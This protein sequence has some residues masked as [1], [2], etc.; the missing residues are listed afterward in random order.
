MLDSRSSSN[1]M[2]KKAMELLNLRISRPYHNICAMDSKTIEVHGLINGL[3]VHLV[4][5]PNIMIEMD[6]ILIDVLDAWGMFLSI[7]IV[8]DLG[9]NLQMDLTYATIST[10]DSAMFRLN[11]ELERRYHV[12][13]PKKHIN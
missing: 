12:E 4:A 3:Q 5:F 7:K 6:I 8:A 2:T 11:R 13:D 9:G 1:V 10:P